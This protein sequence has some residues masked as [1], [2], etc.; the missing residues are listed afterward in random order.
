[1]NTSK[2]IEFHQLPEGTGL[3]IATNAKVGFCVSYWDTDAERALPSMFLFPTLAQAQAYLRA[4]KS[5]ALRAFNG[6]E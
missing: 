6:Q 2:F 3:G 4:E 5:K 1:M